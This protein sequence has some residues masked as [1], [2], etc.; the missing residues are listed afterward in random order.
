MEEALDYALI[1]GAHV[2][3]VLM[4]VQPVSGGDA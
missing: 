2:K 1:V 4:S 3:S